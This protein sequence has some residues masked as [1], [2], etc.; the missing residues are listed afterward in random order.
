MMDSLHL[1][2]VSKGSGGQ[3]AVSTWGVAVPGLKISL[4]CRPPTDLQR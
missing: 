4:D 2:A 1:Q 3:T